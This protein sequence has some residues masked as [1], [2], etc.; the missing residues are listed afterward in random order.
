GGALSARLPD[1]ASASRD[2]EALVQ[3]R[4]LHPHAARRS[5]PRARATRSLRQGPARKLPVRSLIVTRIGLTMSR[6]FGLPPQ[7]TRGG[8]RPCIGSAKSRRPGETHARDS[9]YFDPTSLG[10][11]VTEGAYSWQR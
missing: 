2:G 10:A 6:G 3:H 1:G 7:P 5:F 4:S 11:E 9:S 8:S